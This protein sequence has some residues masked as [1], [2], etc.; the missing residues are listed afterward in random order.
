MQVPHRRSI[1]T[2]ERRCAPG[3]EGNGNSV[4]TGDDGQRIVELPF[5]TGTARLQGYA[6]NRSKR[7]A[8]RPS[9]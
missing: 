6:R 1:G 9:S 8:T 3:T 2:A 5:Q 4:M 7:R